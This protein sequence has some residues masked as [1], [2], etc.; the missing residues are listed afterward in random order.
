MRTGVTIDL[1]RFGVPGLAPDGGLHTGSGRG[2]SA[3]WLMSRVHFSNGAH[4]R[5]GCRHVWIGRTDEPS[6]LRLWRNQDPHVGGVAPTWTITRGTVPSSDRRPYFSGYC[7]RATS[8]PR[9][10][11]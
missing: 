8:C 6:W 10:R 4:C 3:A 9:P 1:Y 11:T 5:L 7:A 2:G